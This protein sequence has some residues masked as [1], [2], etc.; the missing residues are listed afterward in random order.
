MFSIICVY[1]NREILNNYL[2][3]S[4][5]NQRTEY[6]LI[7]IDNTENRYKSAAEALNFGAEKAEKKYLMFVHQDM[8]LCSDNWLM[9]TERLVENL[10]KPG[11]I[12]V[13]GKKSRKTLS[14]ML[15]DYPPVSAGNIL[16]NKPVKVQTVDECLAIIP[17]KLFLDQ[18]FDEITCDNWHLYM[19]DFCLSLPAEYNVYV[20]PT[21]SYHRSPGYSFS[22]S[23]YQTVRKLLRKHGKTYKWIYTTAGNWNTQYPLSF[24][25]KFQ[26]IYMLLVK[27]RKKF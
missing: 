17:R 25:I 9:D 10:E 3:K 15:H 16:I 2:L 26:E 14:N 5:E 21:K 23:Y 8:V 4:L 19:V 11:V 22:P 12:G 13:A 27:L 7:L 20:I 24:Q 6:E 18:K 1:N